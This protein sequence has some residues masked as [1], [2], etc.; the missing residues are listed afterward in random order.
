MQETLELWAII[1]ST[2]ADTL[3]MQYLI[4]KKV[5]VIPWTPRTVQLLSS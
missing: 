4:T 3:I 1:H 2:F 5:I